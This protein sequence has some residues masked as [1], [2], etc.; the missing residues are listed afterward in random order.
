[1][2]VEQR[3]VFIGQFFAVH[4]L[5]T[6]GQQAAIQTNE[7]LFGQFADQRGNVLVRRQIGRAS[8]RE[9]V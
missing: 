8:C 4:L 6:V 5:E 7:V 3:E 1:M 2:T 9:R